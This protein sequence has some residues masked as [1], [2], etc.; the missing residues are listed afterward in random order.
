[1]PVEVG[2]AEVVGDGVGAVAG[3]GS[4][5]LQDRLTVARTRKQALNMK[6]RSFMSLPLR[7]AQGP[8]YSG[9]SRR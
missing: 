1:V 3:D 4:S 7:P 2:A 6:R 8:P 5:A 9:K